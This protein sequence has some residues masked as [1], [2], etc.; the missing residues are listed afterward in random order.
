MSGSTKDGLLP[1][2]DERGRKLLVPY[3]TGGLA[4]TFPVQAPYV[5]TTD[6]DAGPGAVPA[7][8]CTP[9]PSRCRSI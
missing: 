2:V 6:A 9:G 4:G 3:V 8:C 5:V 1:L 7:T